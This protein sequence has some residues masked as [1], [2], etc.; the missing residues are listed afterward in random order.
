MCPAGLRSEQAEA[1]SETTKLG[2]SSLLSWALAPW[3]SHHSHLLLAMGYHLPS[4]FDLFW[5]LVFVF[6]FFC[7]FFSRGRVFLCS[8]GSPGTHSVDQAGEE[9]RNPPASA[10]QVLVLKVCTPMPGL[11]VC[12]SICLFRISGLSQTH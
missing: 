12:L 6:L 11:L 10:S 7:F 8:P 4:S 9:L 1:A 5:L 2:C 3:P